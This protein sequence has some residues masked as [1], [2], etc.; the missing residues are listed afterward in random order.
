MTPLEAEQVREL[1]RQAL[2]AERERCAKIA[3]DCEAERF[4]LPCGGLT[5]EW[6]EG[7]EAGCQFVAAAIRA[8]R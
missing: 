8:A 1:G 4:R 5:D 7:F 6:L 2:I 3:N